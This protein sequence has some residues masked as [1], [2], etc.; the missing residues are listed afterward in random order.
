MGTYTNTT[1]K[2]EDY[3][4][5]HRHVAPGSGHGN[6]KNGV[7]GCESCDIP[8]FCG[9]GYKVMVMII[10]NEISDLRILQVKA[11]YVVNG[12]AGMANQLPS[13]VHGASRWCEQMVRMGSDLS[14]QCGVRNACE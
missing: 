2:T 13:M 11:G 1:A 4:T 14:S 3:L 10:G 8:P 9:K 6:V 12:R 5:L 7:L